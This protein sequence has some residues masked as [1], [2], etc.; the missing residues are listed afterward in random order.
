MSSADP[1]KRDNIPSTKIIHEYHVQLF[2]SIHNNAIYLRTDNTE[3]F[4][5]T[6]VLLLVETPSFLSLTAALFCT[7]GAERIV[8][9]SSSLSVRDC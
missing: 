9:G 3:N 6:L 5:A 4:A 7:A 8:V 1:L 2:K